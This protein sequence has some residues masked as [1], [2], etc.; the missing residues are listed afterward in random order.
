M[1]IKLDENLPTELVAVLS[2]GN[3]DVHTVIDESLTGRSDPTVFEAATR[4]GRILFTQDLD[5]SDIRAFKPGTHPGIVLIRLRHPSRRMITAR[6]Q[7]VLSI[8]SLESWT[9]CFVVISDSKLRVR[10][11]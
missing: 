9:Q 3:H 2:S 4:E 5:F 10:R 6:L 1:K 7:Q 8:Q 11:P